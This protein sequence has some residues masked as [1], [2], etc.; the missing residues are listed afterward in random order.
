MIYWPA[1]E[2]ELAPAWY[3]DGED[4]VVLAIFI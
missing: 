4:V 1:E 2:I 3:A